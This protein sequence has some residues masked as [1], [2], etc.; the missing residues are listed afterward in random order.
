[1]PSSFH[2]RINL[3]L[4]RAGGADSVMYKKAFEKFDIG[5][6][7]ALTAEE[8]RLGKESEWINTSDA[9]WSKYDVNFSKLRPLDEE[10]IEKLRGWEAVAIDMM[11]RQETGNLLSYSDRRRMYLRHLRFWNH[12]I[13]EKKINLFVTSG[14][15]HELPEWIIHGLCRHYGIKNIYFQTGPVMNTVFLVNDWEE[16]AVELKEEYERLSAQYHGKSEEEIKLK[17]DYEEYFL[18]QRGPKNVLPWDQWDTGRK[19]NLVFNLLLAPVR[20]AAVIY[21]ALNPALLAKKLAKSAREKAAYKMF[22]FYDKNAQMP[23]LRKKFVYVPLQFQPEC[24]TCPQGG[25]YTDQLLVVQMLASLLPDDVY[26]YVKE[27]PLQEEWHPDGMG[28]TI[29]FYK[30]L[31]EVPRVRFVPAKFPSSEL[32]K[33]CITTAT[34][35]GTAAFEG[36]F[37][38]KPALLFG[39]RFFQYAPGIFS[40]RTVS[41]CK[42]ALEKI[43]ALYVPDVKDVK[44]FLKAIENIAVKGAFIRD[45]VETPEFGLEDNI[46][47]MADAISLLVSRLLVSR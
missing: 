42:K 23:D 46:R 14:V 43:L 32:T 6:C 35:T 12:L 10:F 41:D 30:D 27:Y 25:A 7:C 19:S 22:R 21:R 4:S 45:F 1:M 33:H 3:I 28:R 5:Y 26:I 37:R 13:L 47:S 9:K 15:P 31:L 17:P 16:P 18:L 2:D 29:E 39:H 40:V 20:G 11:T 38:G 24:S 8:S 34:P 36:L 44:V